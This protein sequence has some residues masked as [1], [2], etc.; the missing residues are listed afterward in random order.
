LD[1]DL[2]EPVVEAEF[3]TLWKYL[4]TATKL[5]LKDGYLVSKRVP[6]YKQERRAPAPFLCT[7]MGR[8]SAE[9]RPFRFSWNRSAAI[10]TNLYL[11]L[12]PQGDLAV[13]LRRQPERGRDVLELLKLVTGCELRGE[14]RVYGGG[15]HKIEPSELGR[16]SAASLI[17]RWPE[18][19][20]QTS[21]CQLDFIPHQ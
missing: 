11:M 4:Q 12:Y 19:V 10:G 6:W 17:Q 21:H 5:G 13:M 2:P 9:K 1:C 18:L 3:S 15:L 14:G 7:Y 8:G 20:R 16:V